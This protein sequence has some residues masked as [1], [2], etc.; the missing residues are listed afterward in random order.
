MGCCGVHVREM[1]D[2]NEKGRKG[3][4]WGAGGD[5]GCLGGWRLG[6]CLCRYRSHP[7]SFEIP[8]DANGCVLCLT[9]L[10]SLHTEGY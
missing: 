2:W 3:I 8:A 4:Q 6:A 9:Y 10:S 7:C 5:P 1:G